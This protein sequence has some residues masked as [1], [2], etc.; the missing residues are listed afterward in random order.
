MASGG[1]RRFRHDVGPAGARGFLLLL[2]RARGAQA[3]RELRNAGRWPRCA[4]S[5]A[6]GVCG[7]LGSLRPGRAM[8]SASGSLSARPGA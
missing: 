6:A 5:A 8:A 2:P 3:A 7:G 1:A 4:A